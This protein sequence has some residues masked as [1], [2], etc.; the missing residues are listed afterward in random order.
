MGTPLPQP[1]GLPLLG[2]IRDIDPENPL[3]STLHLADIYGMFEV[4]RIL[5][6]AHMKTTRPN[7]Q[8]KYRWERK[9]DSL[10]L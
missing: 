5:M 7:L 1:P 6:E 9:G 8:D 2:N 4:L 10:K 3:I